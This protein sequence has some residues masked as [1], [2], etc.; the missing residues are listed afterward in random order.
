MRKPK[1]PMI[2]ADLSEP[3]RPSLTRPYHIYSP[4]VGGT[5]VITANA[6]LGQA[7]P[8]WQSSVELRPD[9]RQRRNGARCSRA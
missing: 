2:E 8:R 7:A 5:G 9:R 1:P 4:G 3:Q 6:I